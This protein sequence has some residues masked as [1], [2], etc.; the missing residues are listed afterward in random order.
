MISHNDNRVE[1]LVSV[2]IEC[3]PPQLRDSYVKHLNASVSDVDDLCDHIVSWQLGTWI[4][5]RQAVVELGSWMFVPINTSTS[6]QYEKTV[7]PLVESL[8]SSRSR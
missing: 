2:K 4:V 8:H 3:I 5:L 6:I 7:T 1:L